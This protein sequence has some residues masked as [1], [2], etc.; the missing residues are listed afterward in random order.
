MVQSGINVQIWNREV[1]KV[2]CSV[3]TAL[4]KTTL[5]IIHEEEEISSD[6]GQSFRDKTSEPGTSSSAEEF[7][8][9]RSKHSTEQVILDIEDIVGKFPVHQDWTSLF[10]WDDFGYSLILGFAPTA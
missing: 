5:E 6:N 8:E 3:R 2:G 10:N 9:P 7:S 4:Y 1:P